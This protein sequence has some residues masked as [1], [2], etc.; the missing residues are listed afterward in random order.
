MSETL[1]LDNMPLE[2]LRRLADEELKQPRDEQGRFVAAQPEAVNEPAA[3]VDEVVY[4]RVIDL[5][6]GSGVQVFEGATPEDLIEKLAV[7]QEHATRKIK[8]LFAAQKAREEA[9]AP[10]KE[11]SADEEF[12]LSQE[13]LNNPSKVL[14]RLKKEAREEIER[15]LET[16]LAP[17]RQ[18]TQRELELEV[19]GQ[20]R[21]V[22]P[23][24]A[25]E[26]NG[27]RIEK[28][29][30]V[31]GLPL[32]FENV[33]KAFADLSESGLLE[34]TSEDSHAV[35]ARSNAGERIAQP[36]TRIVGQRKAASGLSARG[37]ARTTP[38][39][40]TEDDL[41]SMPMDKLR[42]LANAQ[43]RGNN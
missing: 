28:W 34:V 24:F 21:S 11:L 29:L 3:D 6:D 17:V 5:G 33:E 18:L 25:T 31:E 10:P 19:A 27:N 32:S 14:A 4:R 38:L 42:D 30:K 2:E 12:L 15:D 23:E 7:A 8:E 40:P 26:K 41:Y 39:E 43:L 37:S 9:P 35:T 22:H 20:F 1:D 13:L 16:K 36:A